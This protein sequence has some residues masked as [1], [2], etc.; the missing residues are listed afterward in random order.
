MSQISDRLRELDIELP[1]PVAPVAAYVPTARTGSLVF[2]SGQVPI[3]DGKVAERG[4][5][6]DE[7]SE[8]RA[9]DLARLCVINGL[10]ALRAE[11]G[12][13][14][15]ITRIVRVGVFV[16]SEPGYG[17]Q[18]KVANGASSFLVEV[19]GEAGR[20]ARAAVGCS[21]LPLNVPVEVELTVE[22]G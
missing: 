11:L 1:E 15:R 3:A 20:H 21:S 22:V 12:D 19:C 8:E 7:V 9:S 18:P 13:L 17:G 14:D 4:R 5:V 6:P 10:A 2:V 16:N